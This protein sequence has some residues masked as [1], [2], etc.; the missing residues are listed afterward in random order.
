MKITE[1]LYKPKQWK[2][3][4]D[5]ELD[6]MFVGVL[7]QPKGKNYYCEGVMYHLNTKGEIVG[8]FIEYFK[9]QIYRDL[10]KTYGKKY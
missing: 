6:E 4:Y 3:S 2:V 8:F 1:K 10:K 5:A 7:P 9:T